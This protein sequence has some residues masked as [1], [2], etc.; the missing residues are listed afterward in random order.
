MK[1]VQIAFLTIISFGRLC[2]RVKER[3]TISNCGWWCY[4]PLDF[5]V[6]S[7]KHVKVFNAFF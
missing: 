1:V 3:L 7:I 4:K 2:K 6:N 5:E